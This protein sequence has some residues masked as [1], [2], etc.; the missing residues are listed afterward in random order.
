MNDE[1]ARIPFHRPSIGEEEI[2]AVTAVLRSGWLTSGAECARFEEELAAFVGARHAVAVSSCTAALHLALEAAGV[3]R[4]DRV[5]VPTFTFAAT[6]EV[7]AHLGAQPVLVDCEPRTLNLDVRAAERI[8][9]ELEAGRTVPGV[10]VPGP[11][12]AIV[13]V[14]YAGQMAD[15]DGVGLIARRHGLR[16]IEDAAH[17]LP[18]F[19]RVPVSSEGGEQ[20]RWRSVGTTAEQTC[21]SF[22]ANKTITTGEGGMLV[23][24]DAE[25]AARAR[26]MSLHGLSKDAWSRFAAHGSWDYQIVAAGHKYNLTDLAAALGRAQLKKAAGFAQARAE[27]AARY[28]ELL[29]AVDELELPEV[30]P[31]R[32]SAW[33][34]Y[35]AR[36]RLE[37]LAIDRA[38]FVEELG[39]A[40]IGVSVHWRPLHL[41]AYYRDRYALKPG[42]FPVA[43]AEWARCIS[44]PIFPGLTER[45]LERICNVVKDLSRRH[46]RARAARG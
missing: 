23:T 3:R 8:A 28:R 29:G 35:V 41:H 20:T 45:E 25:L 13:P 31:D 4:A 33:H 39:R 18:A 24:N 16:V 1:R 30:S 34:L 40:G 12:A 11:A 32:V 37:R 27:I 19:A 15:V 10:A 22:Y 14:H 9:S 17:A 36:L 2:A 26:S 7:V 44:L 42:D 5:L 43:S 6:A 38:A 46:A 21:F